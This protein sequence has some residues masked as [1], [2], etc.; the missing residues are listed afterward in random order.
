MLGDNIILARDMASI[1]SPGG[2]QVICKGLTVWEVHGQTPK[3]PS[4]FNG[5]IP[6]RPS[7]LR[8]I[9]EGGCESLRFEFLVIRGASN[10]AKNHHG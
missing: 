8:D 3:L 7:N 9:E 10:F 5:G 1:I 2:R 4:I 6:S